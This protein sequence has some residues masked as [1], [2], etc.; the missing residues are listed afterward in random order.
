MCSAGRCTTHPGFFDTAWVWSYVR[1]VFSPP[2]LFMNL[3]LSCTRDCMPHMHG[4]MISAWHGEVIREPCR[5]LQDPAYSVVVTISRAGTGQRYDVEVR[6]AFL[7]QFCSGGFYTEKE[8]GGRHRQ[9]RPYHTK[10]NHT[11]D[12]LK[13]RMVWLRQFPDAL[14]QQSWIVMRRHWQLQQ[15]IRNGRVHS[16]LQRAVPAKRATGCSMAAESWFEPG[17]SSYLGDDLAAN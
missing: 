9:G 7:L 11:Y 4:P 14:Q 15:L 8:K 17:N 13:Q 1:S 5:E 2:F 3:N 12:Q 10:S 6:C 16:H